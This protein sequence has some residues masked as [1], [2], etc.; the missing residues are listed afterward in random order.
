LLLL[1]G[2]NLMEASNGSDRP[3]GPLSERQRELLRLIQGLPADSRHT[4][5]VVFR[6]SEPWEVQTMVEHRILG[7]L[8]P[9]R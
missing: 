6:G 5:T 9:K 1:T 7:D 8:R 3:L 4:L 2:R